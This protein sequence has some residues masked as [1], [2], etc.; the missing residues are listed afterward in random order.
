MLWKIREW[1][2]RDKAYFSR[3]LRDSFLLVQPSR[4]DLVIAESTQDNVMKEM[5]LQKFASEELHIKF[6]QC[7]R[8]IALCGT[9]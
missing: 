7:I 3:T 6:P 4:S 9:G 1:D 8:R 2:S 5:A